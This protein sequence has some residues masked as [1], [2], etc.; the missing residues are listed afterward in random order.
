M[1]FRCLCRL[2]FSVAAGVFLAGCAPEF[3]RTP[4]P[5]GPG[6]PAY[7]VKWDTHSEGGRTMQGSRFQTRDPAAGGSYKRIRAVGSRFAVT[8]GLE[9][10]GP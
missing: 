4:R 9:L 6:I 2:T 10:N 7:S 3:F 1:R 8:G 5:P